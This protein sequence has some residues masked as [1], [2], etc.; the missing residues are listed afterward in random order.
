MNLNLIMKINN[1]I[2]FKINNTIKLNKIIP[3]KISH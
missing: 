1:K 3:I 2:I